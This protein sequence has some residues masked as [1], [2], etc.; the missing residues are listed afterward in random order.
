M[1][2]PSRTQLQMG[3]PMMQSEG[4]PPPTQKKKLLLHTEIHYTEIYEY[5]STYVVSFKVVTLHQTTDER[6]NLK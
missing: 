4:S 1:Q 2:I 3:L 6:E 5:I